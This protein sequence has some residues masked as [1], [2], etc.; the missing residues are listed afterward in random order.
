[1]NTVEI[2]TGVSEGRTAIIPPRQL[3]PSGGNA[4][5]NF[6]YD[7]DRILRSG[8]PL[9]RIAKSS[10][11]SSTGTEARLRSYGVGVRTMTYLYDLKT[12]EPL[13]PIEKD[14]LCGPVKESR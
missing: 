2:T 12:G 4:L 9:S 6:L 14:D 10:G 13:F 7:L 5:V 3:G 1:M 11:I 8:I